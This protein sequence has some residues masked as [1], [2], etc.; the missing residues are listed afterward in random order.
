MIYQHPLA[1]LIAVEGVALM[2]AFAGEY[3]REF[4][5][6][7]LQEVRSFVEGLET[8]GDGVSVPAITAEE[9]YQ[10]WA[11]S[12]DEGPNQ[13]IDLE[14]PVVRDILD[15]VPV[16]MAVDV[17]CGTGRHARYLSDLGHR[18]IGVDRSKGMLARAKDKVPEADFHR[19]DLHH[20]PL[21]DECADVVVCALAL[22]HVPELVPALREM[23]RILRP[24]GHLVASDS[25]GLLG[26]IS[27]PVVVSTVDSTPGYLPHRN[28]LTSEYLAAALPLGLEVRRCEEPRRPSPLIDPEPATPTDPLLTTRPPDIW[29]L[30]R[31][32]PEATNAAYLDNPA[33]IVWHFQLHGPGPT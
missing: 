5:H 15:G 24:G 25:R 27:A 14:Q 2:H 20:L 19:A 11:E 16:G 9:G 21:R 23:V 8:W 26:Y 6:A 7:R 22:T 32:C 31:W 33:A 4:T 13:L 30:H 17:A 18:V 12:Y 3:D 29:L 28:R 10:T 1:Y